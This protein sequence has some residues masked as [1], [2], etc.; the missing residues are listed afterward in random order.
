MEKLHNEELHKLQSAP[1]IIRM[2]KS[3]RMSWVGHAT[4]MREK[5]KAQRLLAGKLDE[6]GHYEDQEICG[7]IILIWILQR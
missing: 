5:G 1:T 6:R 7:W 2:I 3:R 4:Q